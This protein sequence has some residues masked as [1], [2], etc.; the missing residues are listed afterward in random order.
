G[1][2]VAAYLPNIPQAMV[3]MLAVVSIGAVWSVCSPDMGTA[4][5]LDRFEQIAPKA[6]IAVDGVYYAGK[7]MDR[8]SIVQELRAR[9]PSLQH[10]IVLSTRWAQAPVQ[11]A[12][13]WSTLMQR[14]DAQLHSFTPLWL[15]FDHPL[16]IVYSSGTTGL[17]KPI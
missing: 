3:A 16:W 14:D 12:A 4:A 8:S 11:G 7:P 15:P 9:L 10:C 2:R 6:L 5:V 1:D 17:P 13:D